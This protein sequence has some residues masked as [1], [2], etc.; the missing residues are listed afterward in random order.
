[1]LRIHAC[2]NEAAAKQYFTSS[3][4]RGDYYMSDQELPGF[5]GG[6][7]AELLG[8]S[9]TVAQKDFFKLTENRNPRTDKPLTART[10]A[11]RRIG[12][13]FNF[14]CAKGISIEFSLN[15][16]DVIMEAAKG[17]VDFTMHEIERNAKCRVRKGRQNHDRVTGNLVWAVFTHLTS[18]PIDGVPD[19]HLHFHVFAFNST[20]DEKEGCWKAAQIGDI[21]REAPYF[22]SLFHSKLRENLENAG[23]RTVMRGKSVDL[24]HIPESCIDKFSR[25]TKQIEQESSRLGVDN[26]EQKAALGA[27]TRERKNKALTSEELKTEWLARLSDNEKDALTSREDS[28]ELVPDTHETVLPGITR[29]AKAAVKFAVEQ[30]FERDSVVSE[31]RLLGIALQ[32]AGPKT[33]PVSVHRAFEQ[34]DLVRD[35]SS[36]RTLVTTREILREEQRMIAFAKEGRG[37]CVP[38]SMNA[39][40]NGPTRLTD[41]QEKALTELVGSY[42][43]V[44]ILRGAGGVGKSTLMQAFQSAV[45]KK[46]QQV[47]A[48]TPTNSS[49]NGEKGHTVARLLVDQ[50]MQ[51]ELKGQVLWIDNAGMVGVRTMARV[52]DVA[53]RQDARVVLSGDYKKHRPVER[54]GAFGILAKDAGLHSVSLK[55]IQRQRGALKAATASLERG[56]TTSACHRLE[57]MGAIHELPTTD[58]HKQLAQDYVK[59]IKRRQSALVLSPTRRERDRASAELLG[60]KPASRRAGPGGRERQPRRAARVY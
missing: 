35:D 50:A 40:P 39:R 41:R 42:D 28:P 36:G 60:R 23:Y 2:Q 24:E 7:G 10:K 27:K 58:V 14:N 32:N 26:A 43:R 29:D 47:F 56:N 19:P 38:F 37:K 22:E 44:T 6:R 57:R 15:Q 20:F 4:D 21:K 12:Y 8:L 55:S 18:R 45:E 11:N 9:G 49:A 1:M 31:H 30:A 53:Q 33:S 48:Y 52:F 59:T 16:S 13:E 25:R 17:A 3:L 46:G 34:L 51:K 54:G 5:W